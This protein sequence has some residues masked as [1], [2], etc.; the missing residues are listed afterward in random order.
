MEWTSSALEELKIDFLNLVP[1]KMMVNKYGVKESTL[2][3]KLYKLGLRRK[4]YL[5]QDVRNNKDKIIS[6]YKELKN[7]SYIAELFNCSESLIQTILRNA[8]VDLNTLSYQLDSTVFDVIDSEEKAYWLGFLSGDGSISNDLS[9]L[10]LNLSI[11]DY[12]HLFRF[13]LFL[14]TDC[15]IVIHRNKGKQNKINND[16]CRLS[17]TSKSLITSLMKKGIKPNKTFNINLPLLEDYSLYRHYI[18]GLFDADG[19]ITRADTRNAQFGIIGYIPHINEVQ[20]ILVSACGLSKNKIYID[21]RKDNR[22]GSLVYGGCSQLVRIFEFLY[23]DATIFLK[24]KQALWKLV[25]VR[26]AVTN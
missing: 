5:R 6:A 20:N 1:F 10:T 7:I 25:K 26:Y 18:R 9:R 21:K 23:K 4:N 11:R 16:Y 13:R 19:W 22:T 3:D 24:R 2:R 14:K 12:E 15:D 8:G 17:I